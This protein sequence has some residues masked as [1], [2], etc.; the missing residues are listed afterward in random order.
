[1]QK[2]MRMQCCVGDNRAMLPTKLSLKHD[3]N[4]M[5]R[6]TTLIW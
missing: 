2:K 6:L 3:G 1:M 5:M 4:E